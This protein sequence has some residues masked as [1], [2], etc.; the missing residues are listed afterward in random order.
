[1][2]GASAVG[3]CAAAPTAAQTAPAPRG[4]VSAW[5]PPWPSWGWPSSGRRWRAAG[6]AGGDVGQGDVWT[7]V[8]GSEPASERRRERWAGGGPG[9]ALG[10]IFCS[11]VTVSGGDRPGLRARSVSGRGRRGQ[12]AGQGS[13]AGSRALPRPLRPPATALDGFTWPQAPAEAR[14]AQNLGDSG[15]AGR[16]WKAE[17]HSVCVGGRDLAW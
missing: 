13:F 2:R 15:R 5:P 1:M 16:T 4:W 8:D 11:S 6:Q 3:A 9:G 10:A 12:G 14:A 7:A 17:G